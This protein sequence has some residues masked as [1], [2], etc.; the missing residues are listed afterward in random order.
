MNVTFLVSINLDDLSS[1]PDIASEIEAD[2]SESGFEVISV[3]PWARP[4]L[5]QQGVLPMSQTTQQTTI[6]PTQT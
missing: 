2:L 1:L 3:A 5:Q 4:A 6:Q